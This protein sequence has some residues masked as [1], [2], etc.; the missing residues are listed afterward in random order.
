MDWIKRSCSTR[1]NVQNCHSPKC[2]YVFIW[3]FLVSRKKPRFGA[4]KKSVL[5]SVSVCTSSDHT[6]ITKGSPGAVD[7]SLPIPGSSNVVLSSQDLLSRMQAR[8][9]LLGLPDNSADDCTGSFFRSAN[10]EESLILETQ[11][12]PLEFATGVDYHTMTENIR[13]FVAFRGVTPGQVTTTDILNE[14]DGKLPLRGAPLFRALLN[15]L[16]SFTRDVHNQGIWQLKPE[17]Q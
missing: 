11:S 6:E 7:A 12:A 10:E 17:F 13:S 16:C 3:C 8:N 4:K 2:F 5:P 15:Q 9:R 1:R 14:F